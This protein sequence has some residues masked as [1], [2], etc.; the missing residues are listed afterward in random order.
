MTA[1]EILFDT[2]GAIERIP[3]KTI[4]SRNEVVRDL[5]QTYGE[6]NLKIRYNEDNSVRIIYKERKK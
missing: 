5:I 2:G 3:N 1:N 4:H 6:K